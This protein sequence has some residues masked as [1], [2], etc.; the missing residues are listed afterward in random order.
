[1]A[2]LTVDLAQ[3]LA[4]QRGYEWRV[5][6]LTEGNQAGALMA[7]KIFN[8]FDGQ[9]LAQLRSQVSRYIPDIDKT[10][11]EL[12]LPANQTLNLPL[13]GSGYFLYNVRMQ[14]LG[15]APLLLLAGKVQVLPSLPL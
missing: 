8:R 3:S 4:I 6:L 1:M 5:I 10:R 7:G 2:F 12:F 14:R 11:F 13:S 15:R 9:E